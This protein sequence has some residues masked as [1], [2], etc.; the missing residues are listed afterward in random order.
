MRNGAYSEAVAKIAGHIE[1]DD[2]SKRNVVAACI[3]ACHLTRTRMHVMTVQKF[4]F[5]ISRA[6]P[7]RPW[8]ETLLQRVKHHDYDKLT[9]WGF[10]G[11]YAPYIV[12]KYGPDWIKKMFRL[13]DKYGREWYQIYSVQHV[14]RSAHHPE[15]WC[16]SYDF[17]DN[18]PPFDVTAMDDASIAEMT[19][20]NMAVGLEMGNTASEWLKQKQTENWIMSVKQISLM[21]EILNLEERFINEVKGSKVNK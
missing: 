5:R 11:D 13:D 6:F 7:A 20:D 12:K 1:V 18:E 16:E 2:E 10:I 4:A 9:D 19:A 15:H 3:L 14:K 17:G 21:N 8:A